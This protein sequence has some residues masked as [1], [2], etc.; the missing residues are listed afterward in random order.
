MN[1]E[2]NFMPIV[3]RILLFIMVLLAAYEVTAAGNSERVLATWAYTLGFGVLVVAGLILIILGNEVLEKSVVVIISTIIPLSISL[4]LVSDFF[5]QW[6]I[7]YLIFVAAGFV[8]ILFT[9][10]KTNPGLAA[11]FLAPVHGVAGLVIILAP[12]WLVSNW[13]VP[14]K[15]FLWVSLGGAL[16]GLAGLLLYFLRS[17]KVIL[18]Q[19]RIYTIIPLLLMMMMLFFVMGFQAV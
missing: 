9:R 5:P 15:A 16:I 12:I 2:N 1:L 17:G 6:Q 10:L 18:S 13:I 4:G 7:A 11:K 19:K 3:N 8:V 14:E